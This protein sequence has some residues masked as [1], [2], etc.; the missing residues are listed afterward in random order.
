MCFDVPRI[1]FKNSGICFEP[2]LKEDYKKHPSFYDTENGNNTPATP[3]FFRRVRNLYSFCRANEMLITGCETPKPC[4]V[5]FYGRYHISLVSEVH[6]DG[7]FNEIEAA[8]WTVF[9]VEHK[10]KKWKPMDVG[11]LFKN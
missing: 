8:P 7:T 2:L 9:T 1:A 11:R 5:V 4:D 3:F 6:N 10:N